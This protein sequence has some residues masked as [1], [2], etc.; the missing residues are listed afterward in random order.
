MIGV[1]LYIRSRKKDIKQFNHKYRD[2]H[3]G[4]KEEKKNTV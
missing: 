2:W 3:N 4:K 1:A